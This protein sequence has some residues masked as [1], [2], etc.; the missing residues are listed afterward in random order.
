V[1]DEEIPPDPVL[2]VLE[3]AGE[4]LA[5]SGGGLLAAAAGI[6][7]PVA[8]IAGPPGLA[9]AAAGWGARHVLV[10]PGAGT[11]G[12]VVDALVSAA[13]LAG[14][15]AILLAHSPIGTEI[16]ARYAARTRTALALDAV[17]VERDDE[18][19][20]AR[21]SV[22]GGAYEVVS[23]STAG[24]PVVTLREGAVDESAPAAA[25]PVVAQ[26][27]VTPS[28]R[29]EA[30]VTAMAAGSPSAGPDLRTAR[31]VVAGGRGMGSPEGFALVARLAEALGGAVGASRAAVDAGYAPHSAQVGQTGAAVSPELYIALGISGAVQHRA[32]MQ[33]AKTIVAVDLDPAAPI[34]EI[35]DIGVV[36]DVHAVVPQL[37]GAL[38]ARRGGG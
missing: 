31:I 33:T 2:V 19:V 26:L 27:A 21:H 5:A 12:E 8:V 1:T 23:A 13:A 16:A 30:S 37:I 35:A 22:F 25:A 17:A 6:G 4:G 24:P 3:T 14:P 18:G 20:V 32:G 11:P 29:A 7:S 28:G 9:E 38:A 36:G 10:A 15:D 34:F